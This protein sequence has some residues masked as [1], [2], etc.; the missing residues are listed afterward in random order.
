MAVNASATAPIHFWNMIPPNRRLTLQGNVAPM[1]EV[2]G[3]LNFK[4]YMEIEFKVYG[5][6]TDPPSLEFK[7]QSAELQNA[8]CGTHDIAT[9]IEWLVTSV[10]S[11]RGKRT[12]TSA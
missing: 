12:S 8:A 1:D 3:R 2:G 4:V 5:S 7:I 9:E 11:Q 10:P 6:V